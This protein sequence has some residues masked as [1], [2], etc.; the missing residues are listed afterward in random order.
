MGERRERGR[1]DRAA[2]PDGHVRSLPRSRGVESN[3]RRPASADGSASGSTSDTAARGAGAPAGRPGVRSRGRSLF[4]PESS[5]DSSG[6]GGGGGGA[7]AG[8]GGSGASAGGLPACGRAAGGGATAGRG[9]L[10]AGALARRRGDVLRPLAWRAPRGLR[11][12]GRWLRWDRGIVSLARVARQAPRDC[13]PALLVFCCER[14]TLSRT[15][16]QSG[17]TSATLAGAARIGGSDPTRP[18]FEAR[19]TRIAMA[20]A[21]TTM[22][23]SARKSGAFCRVLID[24]SG[25]LRSAATLASHRRRIL[26]GYESRR[27]PL[28]ASQPQ[29]TASSMA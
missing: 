11:C 25:L 1:R 29:T 6:G 24:M 3:C 22:A 7:G 19:L 21:P 15:T 27:H 16:A 9:T 2:R 10:T 17:P 14:T 18:P 12:H 26:V 23:T 20:G 4:Q 5:N 13:R 28:E 8:A